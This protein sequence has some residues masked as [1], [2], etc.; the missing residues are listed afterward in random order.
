M[1]VISVFNQNL[2]ALQEESLGDSDVCVAILDG[3][4]DLSHPC[5]DG[6]NLTKLPSLVSGVPDRSS[7][8]QHGTHIA[9]IIFGQRGSA[10]EGIAPNCRGLLVPVF[11]NGRDGKTASCSQVDLARAITQAVEHGAN[12]INISG[13][14]LAASAESDQLLANAI[15]LCQDN[16]VLIVAAAGNDGCECLHL[17]AALDSVLAVGAMDAKGIPIRS[18]NW[19]EP[20]QKQGILAIGEN[21]FGATVGGGTVARTGTSFATPLV[22]GVVAVLLSIQHQRGQKHNPQVVRDAII[23]SALPCNQTED[24]DSRRCLVGTLNIAGAYTLT[25]EEKRL[26]FVDCRML[27]MVNSNENEGSSEQ[28]QSIALINSSPVEQTLP[29]VI[30]TQ[31][32]EAIKPLEVN[33]LALGNG[34]TPLV[35]SSGFTEACGCAGGGPKQLVYALGEL[36]YDFGSQARLD[37]FIQSIFPGNPTRGI[38]E[39]DLFKFLVNPDNSYYAQSLIW[40]IQLDATPIYAIVPTGPFANVAYNRMLGLLSDRAIDR[41]SMPGYLGGSIRLMSGQ[42][43]PAII[44]EIRGIY[45]WSVDELLRA[46]LEDSLPENNE[47]SKIDLKSRIREAL[48]RIYYDF[49]NLGI[50]PQE[51]ALNYAATNAYQLS[52]AISKEKQND[53]VL[54][55]IDIVKSPVCRAD[56]DC[57]D[58]KLRF[59]DPENSQRAKRVHRF[60]IDVSDVIPVTIGRIRSWSET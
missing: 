11:A 32:A 43:V 50:T 4:V 10:V 46:V 34:M 29:K 12:V 1:S 25:T 54:D 45:G 26:D 20:Y 27:S 7:A 14:Q 21:V 16:N 48:D 49:R 53:Q 5:F 22:S 44:P 6:A 35:N 40:T 56:S 33:M 39:D 38:P 19:G 31:A 57:Y 8:S 55:T 13:G 18:S 24:L 30:G 59:F 47:T 36:S 41:V 15:H 9:S 51:R 58:V 42:V 52:I 2:A 17:P 37:S 28:A 3:P 23:S 60:T